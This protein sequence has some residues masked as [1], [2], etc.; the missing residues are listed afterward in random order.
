MILILQLSFFHVYLNCKGIST[1]EFIVKKKLKKKQNLV[2]P[3]LGESSNNNSNKLKVTHSP[4]V[5]RPRFKKKTE[6]EFSS[7]FS[8]FRKSESDLTKQI[9]IKSEDSEKIIFKNFSERTNTLQFRRNSKGD[10][11]F[12]NTISHAES[13]KSKL[14]KSGRKK[15]S[16]EISNQSE[17][18]KKKRFSIKNGNF[19]NFEKKEEKTK[20]F[21]SGVKKTNRIEKHEEG[22]L[23]V[24]TFSKVKDETE[25]KLENNNKKENRRRKG[26]NYWKLSSKL[27]LNF[28]EE[29]EMPFLRRYRKSNKEKN[30]GEREEENKILK[31]LSNK[32]VFKEDDSNSYENKKS[33]ILLSNS[34]KT[35]KSKCVIGKKGGEG[36]QVKKEGS[37]SECKTDR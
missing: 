19:L 23:S 1:Y 9:S 25:K 15:D 20:Q 34:E 27:N 10:R 33:L 24:R 17:F 16:D 21:F 5:Q 32:K 7:K 26:E 22:S 13:L 30:E 3:S 28:K 29:N 35:I 6:S 4:G 18:L 31:S 2:K 14:S 11:K 12:S 37:G 36:D 8:N